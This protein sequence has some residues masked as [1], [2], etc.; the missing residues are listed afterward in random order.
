M[1]LKILQM[2]AYVTASKRL[3][4]NELYELSMTVEPPSN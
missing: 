3:T 2:M 1:V 4:E